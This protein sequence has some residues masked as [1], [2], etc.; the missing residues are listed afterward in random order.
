MVQ[1][2]VNAIALEFNGYHPLDPGRVAAMFQG[3]MP[4]TCIE[5]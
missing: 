4:T 3:D 1:I 5:A 2:T